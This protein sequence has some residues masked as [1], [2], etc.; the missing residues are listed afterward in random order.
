MPDYGARQ[1]YNELFAA[2]FSPRTMRFITV[3]E[4]E[5]SA[6]CV[7]PPTYVRYFVVVIDQVAAGLRMRYWHDAQE[8]HE[9]VPPYHTEYAP[10]YE[11][12]LAMLI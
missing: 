11:T 2:G 8:R 12:M 7:T 6:V 4:D 1:I 3:D 10:D 9:G 5:H